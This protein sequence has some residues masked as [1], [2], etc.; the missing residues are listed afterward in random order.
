MVLI[1]EL[2][3]KKYVHSSSIKTAITIEIQYPAAKRQ[4]YCRVPMCSLFTQCW[5]PP[6]E[7]ARRQSMT[8]SQAH[9]ASTFA[10]MD[11]VLVFFRS[12][13][14][15]AS[16]WWNAGVRAHGSAPCHAVP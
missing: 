2:N 4:R 8:A 15:A 11:G 9:A 1:K 14:T 7:N 16:R 6:A 3:G 13:A 10:H 12:P 5:P